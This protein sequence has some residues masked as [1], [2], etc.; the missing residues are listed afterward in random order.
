MKRFNLNAIE[1]LYKMW[2]TSKIKPS[3]EKRFDGF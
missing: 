2:N 3:N 1:I